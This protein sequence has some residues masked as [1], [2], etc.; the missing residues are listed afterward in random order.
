MVK[1]RNEREERRLIIEYSVG[2]REKK[3]KEGGRKGKKGERKVKE[4]KTRRKK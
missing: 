3:R 2:K 4:K 1:R